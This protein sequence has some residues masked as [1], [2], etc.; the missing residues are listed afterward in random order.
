MKFPEDHGNI[1]P[2]IESY[3]KRRCVGLADDHARFETFVTPQLAEAF[4]RWLTRNKADA[5]DVVQDA[6]VR[7]FRGINGFPGEMREPGFS[8][9]TL[10][11]RDIQNLSYGEIA[12]ATGVPIGTVMLALRQV[13]AE[14]FPSE[15]V[16][17]Q[18]RRRIDAA[19]GK[20]KTPSRPTWTALAASVVIAIRLSGFLTTLALRGTQDDQLVDA[21]VDRHMQRLVSGSPADV[22]SSD[23]HT[24][25]PW[26]NGRLPQAPHVVDLAAEGFPLVGGRIEVIG[27]TL[28]PS[29]VYSRRLHVI[30]VT[31]LTHAQAAANSGA[32]AR[33]INGFNTMTWSDGN[34]VYWAVSDLNSAELETFARLMRAVPSS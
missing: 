11:L 26:F 5:E 12:E 21:L 24:V 19:I 7:A 9:E 8:R 22:A 29:L 15:P 18:L 31:E 27:T 4:A 34:L 10:V 23:R 17:E 16:P 33:T 6:C 32:L 28:L 13:L 14:R 30:S 2:K 25:K 20:K 3:W 1:S